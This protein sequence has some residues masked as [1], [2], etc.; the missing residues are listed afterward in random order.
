MSE[1]SGKKSK[2]GHERR[3]G[4]TEDVSSEAAGAAEELAELKLRFQRLAA[5]YDNYQKRSQRQIAQATEF[6]QETFAKSLLP[7]LDNFEHTL[8]ADHQSH[9]AA[10]VLEGVQIVHDHLVSVLGSLGVAQINAEPGDEFDPALHQALLHEESAELAANKIVRE[11]ARGYTMNGRA[12]R[13][14]KVAIAKAP[15]TESGPEE[16]EDSEIGDRPG[17]DEQGVGE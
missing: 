14:T 16:S 12:I 4:S 6:A 15:A 5:D 3:E 17:V 8:A 11:L 10:A 1:K 7:V 13:P 9:D 2:G